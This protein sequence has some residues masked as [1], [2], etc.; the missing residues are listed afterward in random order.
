MDAEPTPAGGALQGRFEG[1]RQFQQWLRDAMLCAGDEGWRELVLSD[2]DF[3]DWPLGERPF[4]EAL[5]AWA[6]PGRKIVLLACSFDE[7]PRR[8]ARFVTWRTQWSHLVECLV[9][10]RADPLNFPSAVWS[11][12]WALHRVDPQR[13]TG[14][15]GR[16]PERRNGVREALDAQWQRAT[17]A[18]PASVLG[19]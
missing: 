16:E 18:F 9:V 19:L 5:T 2:A 11:P 4:C 3:A 8:H 15:A 12:H 7:V 6:G 10:R 17:T 14:F 13:C 1:R